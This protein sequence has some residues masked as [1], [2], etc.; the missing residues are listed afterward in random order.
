M[1]RNPFKGFRPTMAHICHCRCR[2][3]T[4][5]HQNPYG[6]SH[7]TFQTKR[8]AIRILPIDRLVDGPYENP[9]PCESQ[10]VKLD[11]KYGLDLTL[12]RWYEPGI[13]YFIR[14]SRWQFAG[15]TLSDSVGEILLY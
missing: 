6:V 5:D 13:M 9:V 12:L 4:I 11:K 15:K 10:V 14:G 8:G 7:I 1:E 2:C 3:C